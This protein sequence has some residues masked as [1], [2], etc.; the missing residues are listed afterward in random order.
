MAPGAQGS[1]DTA[2]WP[3]ELRLAKDRRTLTVTFDS[4]ER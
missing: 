1:S 4:G 3:T 2:V